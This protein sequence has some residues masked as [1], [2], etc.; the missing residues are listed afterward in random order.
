MKTKIF[1]IISEIQNSKEQKHIIPSLALYS[2]I[3]N[4]CDMSHNDMEAALNKL[5]A[6]GKI[7]YCMT[8]NQIA[9]TIKKTS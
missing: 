8:I 5:F 2:E 9:F 7:D 4:K 6:E 3:Y 1:D